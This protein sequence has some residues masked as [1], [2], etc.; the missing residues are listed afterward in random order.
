MDFAA[1]E[2]AVNEHENPQDI[3]SGVSREVNYGGHTWGLRTL[4]PWE[5]AMAALV[6]GRWRGT[7]KEADVWMTAIV[8]LAIVHEDGDP[9]FCPRSSPDDE[10]YA[11]QRL[12]YI[13]RKWHYPYIERLYAEYTE[14]QGELLEKIQRAEN[15]SQPET[16]PFVPLG[17]IL[18]DKG[19][20]PD[21]TPGDLLD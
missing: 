16:S 14:M 6:V 5:E 8:G 17:A 20:L 10:T 2:Q 13:S 19:T 12:Q 15:L 18:R 7:L 11:R 3:L 4:L 21:V 9:D 1:I